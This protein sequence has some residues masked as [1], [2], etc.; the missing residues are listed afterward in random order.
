M[1]SAKFL[2][3]ARRPIRD[4][5]LGLGL[6]AVIAASGV[7]Q[8]GPSYGL[9]AQSAHAGWMEEVAAATGAALDLKVRPMEAEPGLR[10]AV[11][12]GILASVLS[13]LFAFNLWFARH[14]RRAYAP[15]RRR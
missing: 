5:L 1:A 10:H 2:R 4:F 7:A 8:Q 3:R 6:F 13:G 11:T 9:F 14:L 15:R 12:V